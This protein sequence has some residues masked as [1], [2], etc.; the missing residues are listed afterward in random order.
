M[1]SE[2]NTNHFTI[3]YMSA[4]ISQSHLSIFILA[5]V[6]VTHHSQNYTELETVCAD[7]N[8]QKPGS[9]L[10]AEI[11]HGKLSEFESMLRFVV[12]VISIF[13]VVVRSMNFVSLNFS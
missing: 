6:H 5:K 11:G 10:C 1:S 12:A 2:E 8:A 3:L 9:I 4:S 13:N 7:Q